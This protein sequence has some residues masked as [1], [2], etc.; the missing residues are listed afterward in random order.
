MSSRLLLPVL[1]L[2]TVASAIAV[3]WV[4]QQNRL[5]FSELNH[6][7]DERDEIEIEYGRLQL[8]QATWADNNRIEQLA[9]ARLGLVE[10]T[11]ADSAVVQR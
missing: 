8:E 6:L 9:H 11:P 4:R 3:V 1:L 2:A 7:V 10:P 5:A